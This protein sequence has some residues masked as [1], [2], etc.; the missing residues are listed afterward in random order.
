MQQFPACSD[1]SYP[2]CNG[3]CPPGE[4]CVNL[5]G[6]DDCRCEP[7]PPVCGDS[8][9]PACE[10]ECPVDER[11]VLREAPVPGC[12]CQ[13]CA[14]LGTSGL[15]GISVS[16][17]GTKEQLRWTGAEACA[18]VYNTYRFTGPRLPDADQNDLAD[19]YGSCYVGDIIGFDVSDRAH[20]RRGRSTGTWSPAR[21]S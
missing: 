9:Y 3:V 6:T 4:K 16:W 8:L 11:C 21:T 7:P 18:L 13:P 2:E 17:P 1:T 20:R 19:D 5:F 10:G 15:G 12:E 14:G